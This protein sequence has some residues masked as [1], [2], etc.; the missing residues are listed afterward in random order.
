MSRRA[1][2]GECHAPKTR[3]QRRI[4]QFLQK[5]EVEGKLP[6]VEPEEEAPEPIW[7]SNSGGG[8]ERN[9]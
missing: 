9:E 5:L 8:D 7:W 3:T 2:R 4:E 1:Q 6:A